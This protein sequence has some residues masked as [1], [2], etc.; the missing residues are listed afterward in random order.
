[1]K[2]FVWPKTSIKGKIIHWKCSWNEMTQWK[3]AVKEQR[4]LSPKFEVWWCLWSFWWA[5]K[6]ILT[7]NGFL[8]RDFFAKQTKFCIVWTGLYCKFPQVKHFSLV[9]FLNL[10]SSFGPLTSALFSCALHRWQMYSLPL[11]TIFSPGG[12]GFLDKGTSI[13]CPSLSPF[14]IKW[15]LP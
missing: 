6:I 1:M 14:W 13:I 12:K 4:I 8:L 9:R 2:F 3:I 15:I 11:D 5:K 7:R 10:L